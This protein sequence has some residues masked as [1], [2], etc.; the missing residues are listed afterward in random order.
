M[1]KTITQKYLI[2]WNKK[3][4]DR[5]ITIL[6]KISLTKDRKLIEVQLEDG[7][8]QIVGPENIRG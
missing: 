8:T 3:D 6:H 7:S 5:P 2:S 1:S 4:P